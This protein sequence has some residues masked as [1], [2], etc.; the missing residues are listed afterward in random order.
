VL[1]SAQD[2]MFQNSLP[3]GC[4]KNLLATGGL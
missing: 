3:Q 1:D 2:G 4:V